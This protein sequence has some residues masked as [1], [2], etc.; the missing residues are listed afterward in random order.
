MHA[1]LYIFRYLG[2][3]TLSLVIALGCKSDEQDDPIPTQALDLKGNSKGRNGVIIQ[4][5]IY[6]E[7]ST[8][9]KEKSAKE[10][11]KKNEVCFYELEDYG[12]TEECHRKTEELSGLA[13]NISSARIKGEASVLL[14]VDS[15]KSAPLRI[16]EDIPSFRS[17]DK[18]WNN[19]IEYFE[20]NSTE[21][22]ADNEE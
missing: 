20:L 13:N 12:G 22:D 11:S 10:G 4:D 17:V 8:A 9:A 18:F 19:N 6:P 5:S 3:L 15:D 16:T 1:T 7:T 21:K 2:W 14:Y